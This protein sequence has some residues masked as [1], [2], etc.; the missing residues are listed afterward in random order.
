M[1]EVTGFEIQGM[2]SDEPTGP[3]WRATDLI[4]GR[5]VALKQIQADSPGAG[6]R[7]RTVS[8]VLA[9][10]PHPNIVQVNRLIYRSEALWLVTEWVHGIPLDQFSAGLF[11]T[12]QAVA[13][14]AGA[15]EG[16]AHAHQLGVV[17][18]DVCPAKIM[19]TSG[20]VPRLID[21]GLAGPTGTTGIPANPRFTS[22]ESGRGQVLGPASD[23]YSAAGVLARLL[24]GTLRP[25]ARTAGAQ[26]PVQ[27][28]PS[29]LRPVLN[30]ALSPD[31]ADRYPDAG[32]MFAA[33]KDAAEQSFG[34]DW[35]GSASMAKV[36]RQRDPLNEPNYDA[37]L[38]A[39]A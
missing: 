36:V 7:L 39:G 17:H 12:P 11:T 33:L 28:I 13:T 27:S 8:A 18:G 32:A 9:G 34:A 10:S 20:G 24:T 31:P 38:P 6:S 14:M 15:V 35:R 23:V 26:P 30:R 4:D 25:A 37:A 5:T 29:P 16:L 1:V 2:V 19:L 22:L 21:F 3:V